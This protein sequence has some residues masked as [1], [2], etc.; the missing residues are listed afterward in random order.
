MGL[1][2]K[3]RALPRRGLTRWKGCAIC[4]R[5]YLATLDPSLDGQVEVG[6]R[7]V[8]LIHRAVSALS[9]RQNRWWWW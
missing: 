2:R 1:R 7:E 3:P 5:K 6:V 8:L 4:L 9:A